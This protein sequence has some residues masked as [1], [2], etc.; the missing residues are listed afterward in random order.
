MGSVLAP[1][2]RKRVAVVGGGPAGL[3]FLRVFKESGLDWEVVLFEAR[4]EIGGVWYRADDA[5]P[6]PEHSKLPASPIYDSLT[7]NL[8][9]NVMAFHDYQFPPGTALFPLA[10]AIQKYLLDFAKDFNLRPYIHLQS[11]VEEAY[12]RDGAWDIRVTGLSQVER[13]DHLV[14]ANGHYNKP[15]EPDFP[16]LREWGAAEGRE[17]MHSTWYRE[18]SPYAGKRVVVIGGGPSGRDLSIEIAQVAAETYHSVRGSGRDDTTSPKQ[19]PSPERFEAEGN[20][21]V[22]YTDGSADEGIDV[23]ILATGYE[24]NVPFLPQIIA[25]RLPPTVEEFPQHLWNSRAHIYP[26]ARHIFPISHDFPLSSLAFI[27]LP[28]H[29]VPFPLCEAQAVAALH[30]FTHPE[31]LE[32]E[33]EKDWVRARNAYL[34]EIAR[35]AGGDELRTVCRLWHRISDDAQFEYRDTLLRFAGVTKWL[36]DDWLPEIFAKKL[37]L[38]EEWNDAARSGEGEGLVKDARTKEDWYGVLLKLLDRRKRRQGKN[39]E[40]TVEPAGLRAKI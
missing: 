5:R 2:R 32:I 39:A 14:V 20:G 6:D 40:E 24:H 26:L 15:Y 37:V 30:V 9:V 22:I 3:G 16:G 7:T 29:I 12:W 13:F 23:V 4:D 11:P 17:V 31:T 21:K 28:S 38:R 35:K 25:Q 33:Q 10:T 27:G 18:P 34:K 36:T 8:P 19:R 1:Q